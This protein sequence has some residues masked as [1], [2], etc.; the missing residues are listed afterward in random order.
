M[1]TRSF[2]EQRSILTRSIP[3]QRSILTRSFPETRN[4]PT[5]RIAGTHNPATRPARVPIRGAHGSRGPMPS[6]L[7]TG[8][9]QGRTR[10][11]RRAYQ[12][13]ASATR[14]H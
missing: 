10:L 5:R 9:R 8:V 11:P 7:E 2:P 14:S 4:I 13:P 12:S 1:P 6:P 3:E